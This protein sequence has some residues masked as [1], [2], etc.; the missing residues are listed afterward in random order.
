[1]SVPGTGATPIRCPSAR[2]APPTG[3]PRDGLR[4]WTVLTTAMGVIG[5][6]LTGL[7][8]LVV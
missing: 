8:R 4:T 5:F 1:M 6:A 3:R 2:T 7:L